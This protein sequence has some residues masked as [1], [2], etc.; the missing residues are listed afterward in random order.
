[1]K[2]TQQIIWRLE[3]SVNQIKCTLQGQGKGTFPVQPL[4]IPKGQFAVTDIT[5]PQEHV[6]S[7]TLRS[8]KEL[9]VNPKRVE[10]H[11]FS[12]SIVQI[13]KENEFADAEIAIETDKDPDPTN[14]K[15]VAPFPQCLI[16]PKHKILNQEIL[17]VFKEVKINLP[18]LDV[19]KQVPT[20]A[21][22][23]KDLCTT[24]RRVNLPK[25]GFLIEHI[26]M[27]LNQTMCRDPGPRRGW[28]G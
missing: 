23:L 16:H 2:N 18:L 1:M 25:K 10:Q 7:V 12:D 9:K 5:N 21:K 13:E 8:G 17:E 6:Q 14:L 15:L 20:C 28:R 27:L 24:K 22:F 4:P 26:S 3:S 19:I 11:V